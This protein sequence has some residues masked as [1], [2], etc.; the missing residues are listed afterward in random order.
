MSPLEAAEVGVV[1]RGAH[2]GWVRCRE[3]WPFKRFARAT[4]SSQNSPP[5]SQGLENMST[6]HI[7]KDNIFFQTGRWLAKFV[8]SGLSGV[9][10]KPK[11]PTA[12]SQTTFAL[13]LEDS[14]QKID[15]ASSRANRLVQHQ[16]FVRF[17]MLGLNG[18]LWNGW[19]RMAYQV[20]HKH[21]FGGR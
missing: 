14:V 13:D 1:A 15:F 7:W 11:G 9:S 3:P 19:D 17:T 4:T 2:V 16:W 8:I 5:D 6:P 20:K 10:F 18:W 12:L 21:C